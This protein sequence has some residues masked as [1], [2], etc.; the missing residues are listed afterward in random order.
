[1]LMRGLRLKYKMWIAT[2]QQINKDSEKP[3]AV[4]LFTDNKY[5]RLETIDLTGMTAEGFRNR[6][7]SMRLNFES[8]FT[9]IDTLDPQTFVLTPTPVILTPE[10]QKQAQVNAAKMALAQA[11]QDLALKLLTQAEYDQKVTDYKI[12]IAK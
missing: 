12:L 11:S 2:L 3:T 4:V 7:E 6:V 10:Q 1:M 9:F 5:K 8:S